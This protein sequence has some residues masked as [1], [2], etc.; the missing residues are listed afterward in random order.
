MQREAERGAFMQRTKLGQRERAG[1]TQRE[2]ERE[3]GEAK[4]QTEDAADPAAAKAAQRGGGLEFVTNTVGEGHGVG[5]ARW[6]AGRG[7]SAPERCQ[8][9]AFGLQR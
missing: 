2:D 9:V 7:M 6:R 4:H 3:T 8:G 1:Q 5:K